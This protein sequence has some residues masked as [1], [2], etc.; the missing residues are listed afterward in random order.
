MAVDL[1]D[2]GKT[3]VVMVGQ[4]VVVTVP[5]PSERELSREMVRCSNLAVLGPLASAQPAPH[6]ISVLQVP[7]KALEVGS[8]T[9][10]AVGLLPLSVV[11]EVVS[12]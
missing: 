10:T 6:L 4:E 9:I 11:V 3:I 2:N 7:F 12:A 5:N 8:A 1:G